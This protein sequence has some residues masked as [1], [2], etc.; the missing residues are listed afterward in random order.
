M[1]GKI[2]I[3]RQLDDGYRMAIRRHNEQVDKNL[4]INCIRF[5]GEYELHLRGHDETDS[6]DNPGVLRG[7]ID[8]VAVR[9]KAVSN[10]L[11]SSKNF[12]RHRK[13]NSERTAEF[14]L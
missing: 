6:S 11:K 7:P 14:N 2:D 3:G 4:T 5:C 13:D 12:S 9:G 1:F 10:H 8:F